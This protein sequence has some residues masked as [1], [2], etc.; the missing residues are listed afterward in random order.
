[1]EKY[2]INGGIPLIGETV[3]SGAKNVA[4]KALVAA[5]L[6]PEP[7][8]I[9]NVPLI[10]D[11]KI[12][13]EIIKDLGGEVSLRDHSVTVKMSSFVTHEIP[14][15]R[16]AEVR[17]SSMFIA[18]LLLR[19]GEALTPNPG[20]C[21]L[22]ARPIDRTV[23]GLI[24]MGAQITYESDD[25]F[26]HAKTEGLTGITYNF[27]KNTHT[28]T[29]TMLMAA[30]LAQGKTVLHNAAAEPEVDELI[31]LLVSMGAKIKRTDQRTI[32]IEGVNSLHSG[33]LT[34]EPDRNEIV[35]IACGAILTNGDV[36]VKDAKK[37]TL[38]PFLEKLDEAGGGYEVQKSGI[39][40]F[41]KGEL[42]GTD[43]TTQPAPGFMTDWQ[44]PWTILMTKATGV[45]VIH[46]TVFENRL[47]YVLELRK[48][49]AK[50]DLFNPEVTDPHGTYNF[51][52]S[53]DSPTFYHAARVHGPIQLHNG[54]VQIPDIRAGA[55]L[56]LAALAAKGKSV[57]LGIEKLDRGYE[58]LEERLSNLGADIKRVGI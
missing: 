51:N 3:V 18:P 33:E 8:T 32:E 11:L 14:L 45:S 27:E 19:T 52:L 53:D 2:I 46:E 24:E 54:I 23:A 57:L 36:F 30:T 34:I 40:F 12:M 39:R 49:G 16:A 22:G 55:S 56:V 9:H 37:D 26:F 10:S 42:K 29:E 35:T 28:G 7:V 6:S 58:K 25:G 41:S 50:I 4:L 44:G 48:M 31:T 13:I 5:C 15:D 47:G 1:M 20:G 17:T 38:L 43:V 21:R